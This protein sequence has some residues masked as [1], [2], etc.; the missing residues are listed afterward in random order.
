MGIASEMLYGADVPVPRRGSTAELS[1]I[2]M[3]SPEEGWAVGCADPSGGVRDHNQDVEDTREDRDRELEALFLHYADGGWSRLHTP[4]RGRITSMAMTSAGDGWAVG[5]SV[6]K[7]EEGRA[8]PQGGH[9]PTSLPVLL[10]C[11]QGTWS[12]VA[13]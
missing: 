6:S 12:V 4:I 7:R 1:A 13:S 2:Y 5:T 10:Q 11:Q 3:L 9:F 8:A